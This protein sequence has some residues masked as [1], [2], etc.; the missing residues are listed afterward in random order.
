MLWPLH[1][2]AGLHLGHGSCFSYTP[3]SGYPYASIPRHLAGPV[4]LS[5]VSPRGSFTCPPTLFC[6]RD[7]H[8]SQVFQ[9]HTFPGSAVSVGRL[10]FHLFQGFSVGGTPLTAAI[11][12]RR[13]SVMRLAYREPV[14]VAPRRSFFASSPGSGRLAFF[15]SWLASF[16]AAN[17]DCSPSSSASIFHGTVRIWRLHLSVDG[18]SSR[19]PVVAPSPSSLSRRVSAPS[20]SCPSLL[21]RRLGRGLGRPSRLSGRFGPVGHP[22]GSVVYQRQGTASCSAGAFPVPV[23]SP[24]SHSGCLLRQHHS[25]AFPSQGG[26]PLVSSPQHLSSGD[27]A[28]DGVHLHPPASPVP[29]GLR[30]RP[31]RLPVSPSP[32]HT[33][34]V[35]FTHDRL[36]VFEKTVA[37]SNVFFATSATHRGSIYFSPFRDPW[38]AGTD[39]FLQIWDSLRAY[40]FP[41]VA[42]IRVL[43][44]SSGHPR[45]RDS[46]L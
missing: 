27:L 21:V 20:V 17:W 26:W 36:S 7:C 42:V 9:P 3:F 29:S 45:G 30:H 44:R 13:I 5:G 14:A 19:S 18:V 10:R 31:N 22:S 33:S 2:S 16:L 39:A 23:T 34:R 15:L 37:G 12:S 11:Y 38:S 24:R 46:L 41:P 28:L 35:V 25:C 1:G 4:L 6:F 32:A 40:A 43:S 8:P